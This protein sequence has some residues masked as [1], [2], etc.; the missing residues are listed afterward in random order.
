MAK[1]Q[2]LKP[3]GLFIGLRILKPDKNGF[4][5]P[6][7]RISILSLVLG[8]MVMI[9]SMTVLLGFKKEI[10]DKLSGFTG[11]IQITK[12]NSNP[13][14]ELPGLVIDSLNLDILTDIDGVSKIERFITKAA[15]VRTTDE[16]QGLMVKGVGSDFDSTFFSENLVKGYIP[17]FYDSIK[18]NDVLISEKIAQILKIDTGDYLRVYFFDDKTGKLRG[19]RFILSGIYSTSVEEF[20]KWFM[21]A[22]IRHLQKINHWH[23]NQVSGIEIFAND[24]DRIKFIEEEVYAA[25]P[26]N[27]NTSTIKERY[28]QLFDW[29]QLQDINVIIILILIILVSVVSM[30]ST[31]LV[32]VIE[33]TKM[34]G[35]LKALGARNKQIQTI[36]LIQAFYIIA[37]GMVIGNFLGLGLAFIQKK[38]GF[39]QLDAETYYMSV[40]PIHFDFSSIAILNA[41]SLLIILLFMLLP[42]W[43]TSKVEPS[44][45]I[46]FD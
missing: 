25:I 6:I 7:I 12:Y 21:L 31:I 38:Y 34:I 14:L 4:S 19:R 8:L 36:F 3:F 2:K 28:P 27:M 44:K 39:I 42:T 37:L 17:N 40:V 30:I 23:Q 29:L 15:I 33:R 46:R 16:M 20:D 41:A 11:H 43:V 35:I 32:L 26:Y 24:F 45:T 13:S 5:G 18:T 10:R 22:D 1:N 9:I